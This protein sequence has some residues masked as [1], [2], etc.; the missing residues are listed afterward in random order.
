MICYKVIH[1]FFTKQA[2]H[3]HCFNIGI[4]KSQKL[5]EEAVEKLKTKE[6]FKLRPHK[7]HI[8]KVFRFK[9][10]KLLN[11]TYWVDGFT[12]YTYQKQ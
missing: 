9:K 10:P 6:G 12:T 11:Q 1:L 2:D 7:F 4:Y 5:A 3:I 8:L